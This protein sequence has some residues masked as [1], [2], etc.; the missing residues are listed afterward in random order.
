MENLPQLPKNPARTISDIQLRSVKDAMRLLSISR[1]TFYSLVKQ[2]RIK[3]I[4]IGRRTYVSERQL[5]EFVERLSPLSTD[6]SVMEV[7]S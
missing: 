4:K 1:T 5:R 6:A 3:P 2:E 7:Q